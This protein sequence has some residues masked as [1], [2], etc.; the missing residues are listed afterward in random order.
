VML[1][2]I[3]S[4]FFAGRIVGDE[5]PNPAWGQIS[6]PVIVAV[7]LVPLGFALR[8][9]GSLPNYDRAIVEKDIQKLQ[10]VTSQA[11]ADNRGEVLF[12]TERQLLTFKILTNIPLIPEYEQLEL[13]EMA[14]SG[15]REYLEQYYADLN[16]HRFAVIIAEKQKKYTTQKRIP[17]IEENNA[18]VRFVGA[19][20]LCA[21]E[22]VES[23]SSTNVQI[24]VPRQTQSSC[25][26]PFSE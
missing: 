8:Q 12:I 24:F 4:S 10:Q 16:D 9:I 1:A 21:Y 26:D 18:W 13:M 3:A 2:L 22:P 25:K 6:W 5:H 11:A 19:P 17:F 14:M 15:N 23:L 7:I 20:L